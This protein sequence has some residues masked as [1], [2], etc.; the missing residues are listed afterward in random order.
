MK[1]KSV[2]ALLLLAMFAAAGLAQNAPSKSGAATPENAVVGVWRAEADGLPFVTLTITNEGGSLAGAVLFYLHR[3]DPGQPMTSS[4]GIP[5]PLINPKF[6][7]Q[8]LT[9]E[10]SHKHANPPRSLNDRA[11]S[12]SLKMTGPDTGELVSGY[13]PDLAVAIIKDTY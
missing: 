2:C 11:L 10:V 12:F 7:G 6:D 3:R 9:F 8:T 5:E 4:P 13:E 1:F